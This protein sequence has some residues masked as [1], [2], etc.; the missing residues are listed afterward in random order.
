ML[1]SPFTSADCRAVIGVLFCAEIGC[2]ACCLMCCAVCIYILY[3]AD[4]LVCAT[5]F[6][7]VVVCNIVKLVQTVIISDDATNIGSIFT[8]NLHFSCKGITL[9]GVW[10]PCL[11]FI[12][13]T[14]KDTT[15]LVC[16]SDCSV[17]FTADHGDLHTVWCCYILVSTANDT[18]CM[19][20]AG[21]YGSSELA[22][23]YGTGAHGIVT[24]SDNTAYIILTIDRCI[25]YTVFNDTL[26]TS[27]KSPDLGLVFR[28]AYYNIFFN[29]TVTDRC[30]IACGVAC[31]AIGCHVST[32]KAGFP[33]TGT[34]L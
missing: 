24:C 15:N 6:C 16:T 29:R 7:I 34:T 21:F 30:I 28:I 1:C 9:H 8:G 12:S 13:I 31:I 27:C 4:S 18:A 2:S 32:D 23:P 33:C 26:H 14:T 25:A 17:C 19:L 10:I 3:K 5:V 20:A 11:G 22:S